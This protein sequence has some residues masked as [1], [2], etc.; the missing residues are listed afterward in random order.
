MK[1]KMYLGCSLFIWRNFEIEKIDPDLV[2]VEFVDK[3]PVYKLKE[4]V[5]YDYYIV[6]ARHEKKAVAKILT[7][8]RNDRRDK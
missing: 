2:E 8:H 1:V 4:P 6:Q 5:D 3:K 7:M